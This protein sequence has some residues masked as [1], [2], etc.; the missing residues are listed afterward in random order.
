VYV[1]SGD[2]QERPYAGAVTIALAWQWIEFRLY[3]GAAPLVRERVLILSDGPPSVSYELAFNATVIKID[4]LGNISPPTIICEQR[5]LVGNNPPEPSAKTLKYKTS[6][7]AAAKAYAGPVTVSPD[8]Q[9]IEFTLY[10]GDTFLVRETVPVLSDGID[11][12]AAVVPDLERETVTVTADVDG[13]PLDG[14]LPISVKAIL[15]KGT[16][17]ITAETEY[18]EASR[19]KIFYYPAAGAGIMYPALPG[20]YPVSTRYIIWSLPAAPPGVTIDGDGIITIAKDAVLDVSNDVLVRG[21]YKDQAFDQIL[22]IIKTRLAADGVPGLPGADG[23]T[24]YTWIR[25]ADGS[26]GEGLS[27]NP[28]GKKYIGFA[29]NE[30]TPDESDDPGDYIFSL[31]KGEDGVPGETGYTWIRYSDYAD[32]AGMYQQPT[33]DTKYIGIAVN[34]PTETESDDPDEYIWSLFRGSDGISPITLD[35]EWGAIM[36][37]CDYL[38]IPAGNFLPVQSR[39]MLKKGT[40]EISFASEFNAIRAKNIIR[41]PA[42]GNTVM[43]PMLPGWYPIRS[44][45][46]DWS[47]LNAPSGVTIDGT[48]LV[49]IAASAALGDTNVITVRAV[50]GGQI[51]TTIL[52]ITKN[53]GGAPGEPGPRGDSAK[54][55]RYRGAATTAD[56]GNTGIVNI[57]GKPSAV[58]NP[59]DWVMFTG[60]S[61]WQ[62][63]YVY[64]WNGTSWRQVPRGEM[65]Y[66]LDGIGDLTDNAPDGIFSAVFCR[67]L[68]AQQAAIETLQ[69]QLIQIGN[70]IF[71]GARFERQGSAVV[72]KGVDKTGFMIGADGKLV[73]TNGTLND[74]LITGKSEFRG[75]IASGPLYL[76]SDISTGITYTYNA[77]TSVQTILDQFGLDHFGDSQH[78][79]GSYGDRGNVSLLERYFDVTGNTSVPGGGTIP[80]IETGLQITYG[81]GTYSRFK[82]TI[83]K[84]L[85]ATPAGSGK[86]L[87]LIDMPTTKPANPD[88]VYVY[89]DT[90]GFK[91][92]MIS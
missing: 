44:Y 32:G 81:D 49:T 36:V 39:A 10:D 76:S 75:S 47:L 25:Y 9:W 22:T 79:A 2:S 85:T 26:L 42:T 33:A 55:P 67:I 53:P 82:N 46:V 19:K 13:T 23:V 69:S 8:W 70:A 54:A 20:Q 74:M 86:T 6:A 50:Y 60:S 48:G 16:S 29:Y 5:A 71:G 17:A 66:Y 18:P 52:S 35:M 88:G 37:P 30:T 51:Y 57:T 11:G 87:K 38:G 84:K 92:L 43:N 34:K 41:Y 27:N 15:Y 14:I 24:Y 31:I 56:T 62:Y 61:G 78:V 90:E 64:E 28:T 68:F 7:D 77:G 12:A 89:T 45:P 91:Y 4:R 3:D 63:A 80:V 1:V 21:V 58:M 83:D 59:G 73:A 72:D 65:A 40:T